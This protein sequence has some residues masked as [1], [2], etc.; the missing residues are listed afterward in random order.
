MNDAPAR[1]RSHFTPFSWDDALRL[2]EQLTEEERAIRD[3][4]RE[5]CQ[6]QLFPRVIEANRHEK[7]HREI[8]NEMGAMGFLGATLRGLWL[9]R[10]QLCQ[11]RADRARGG[12]RRLRLSLGVFRAVLARDVSDPGL[13]LRGAEGKIPAE[14][15]QRRMGRLL[16]PDRTGR[17]LRSRIDAHARE[18]RRRR[19]RAER[20]E[21]LDHQLADRRCVRGVG[22]GRC[23]RYPRLHPGEGDA[24]AE[25]AEDRRQVLAARIGHRHDHDG[26]VSRSPRMR[27]CPR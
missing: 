11:L 18:A 6:E 8:M 20:L 7:F 3:A 24:G 14:A 9:R 1:H 12:A 5:Y 10:R 25:R 17:R 26:H 27:C 21:D 4:A 16:R 19:L 15:A 22:E 13:R 2:D 23:R